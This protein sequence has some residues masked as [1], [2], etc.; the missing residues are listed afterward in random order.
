[1]KITLALLFLISCT[2]TRGPAWVEGLLSGD[3]TVR[4]TNGA[5]L[6]YRQFG[7]NCAHAVRKAEALISREYDNPAPVL[8]IE[9]RGEGY[10]AVTVSI[11]NNLKRAKKPKYRIGMDRD[12]FMKVVGDYVSVDYDGE[13][14]CWE[15]YDK[16]GFTVHG[17]TVIC[18]KQLRIVGFYTN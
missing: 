7:Y 13:S 18:W 14:P 16:A 12:E 11:A 1:M 9:W 5:R 15:E 4:V 17:H 10:C 6:L 3:E 8:E 2:T